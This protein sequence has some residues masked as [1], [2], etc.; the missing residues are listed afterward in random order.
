MTMQRYVGPAEGVCIIAH[1]CTFL[2]FSAQKCAFLPVLQWL[3]SFVAYILRFESYGH[4]R[5]SSSV[6]SGLP[7]MSMTISYCR[8][9]KLRCLMPKCSAVRRAH[10]SRS[11]RNT[12][13]SLRRAFRSVE[14]GKYK[15]ASLVTSYKFFFIIHFYLLVNKMVIKSGPGGRMYFMF[16]VNV[17]LAR[18]QG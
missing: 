18:T 6:S 10:R 7:R 11:A 16:P 12:L 8:G 14:S 2:P 9:V 17:A 15:V 4:S 1:S 3:S 13:N 5:K